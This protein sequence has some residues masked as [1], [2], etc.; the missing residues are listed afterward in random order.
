MTENTGLI[1][2]Q[3]EKPEEPE[4]AVPLPGAIVVP[5]PPPEKKRQWGLIAAI[6]ALGVLL[7][8]G[9]LWAMLAQQGEIVRQQ[10]TI[11][12]LRDDNSELTNN[13]VAAQNNA[14]DLYDQL[15]ALG[16]KPE[17]QDPS[18][19]TP[20]VNGTNGV[21]GRDGVDGLNGRDGLPGKDGTPGLPGQNGL[22]G[23][24]GTDGV[25]GA[26]GKD[27]A[28]GTNG[29]NG[30]DGKDG[31]P[32]VGISTITCESGN[33]TFTLTDGRVFTFPTDTCK[34]GTPTP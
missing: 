9:V 19:V 17:G 18:T 28:P 4:V 8:G 32:G 3:S 26:D 21:N 12:E 24:D 15:L 20:P 31:A 14:N 33:L 1:P 16:E 29:T 11:E 10:K 23:K 34:G 22:D 2:T 30:V 25:N 7:L 5:P 13:L 6:I 27:G